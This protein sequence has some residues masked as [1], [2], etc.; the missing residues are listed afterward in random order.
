MI[1]S[2]VVIL[3]LALWP[4]WNAA[5]NAHQQCGREMQRRQRLARRGRGLMGIYRHFLEAFLGK[6]AAGGGQETV[7]RAL[8]FFFI[9]VMQVE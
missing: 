2:P 1:A 4:A 9:S 7:A 8:R 3:Q 6:N 5:V